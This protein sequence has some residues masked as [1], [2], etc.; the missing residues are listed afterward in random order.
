MKM[1]R[2]R[3]SGVLYM[4][5]IDHPHFYSMS[6]IRRLLERNGFSRIKFVHL[7][8]IQGTAGGKRGVHRIVKN[9]CFYSIYA[10]SLVSRGHLNFDNLFVVA[11]KESE[12]IRT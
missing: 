10:L 8:P 1:V 6:S 3:Q 5:A 4:K 9:I 12:K 2:S 11:R 7:P